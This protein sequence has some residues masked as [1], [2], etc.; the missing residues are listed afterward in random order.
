MSH[1]FPPLRRD[2]RDRRGIDALLTNAPNASATSIDSTLAR[3]SWSNASTHSASVRAG[4]CRSRASKTPNRSA[5]SLSIAGNA[6]VR[7]FSLRGRWNPGRKWLN[8]RETPSELRSMLRERPEVSGN[9]G[10]L[11]SRRKRTCRCRIKIVER[12]HAQGDR[13]ANRV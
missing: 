1:G 5:G 9:D 3:S 11:S 10:L 2:G 12:F 6:P 7:A 4:F 13:A 8:F